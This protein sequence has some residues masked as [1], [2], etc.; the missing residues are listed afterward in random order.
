MSVTMSI[1]IESRKCII[2][3]ELLLS[4]VNCPSTSTET[5]IQKYTKA[6]I[7]FYLYILDLFNKA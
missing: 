2:Y 4:I 7:F 6:Q 5:N 1:Q 3:Q